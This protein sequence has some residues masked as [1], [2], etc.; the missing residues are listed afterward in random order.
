MHC[1]NCSIFFS[2]FLHSSFL[3]PANK[4][5]LLEWKVRNDLTMYAS[6]ASPSLNLSEITHYHSSRDLSWDKLFQKANRFEDDGHTSKLVRAIAHGEK[7][8][9]NFEGKEG[10]VIKGDMWRT[11]GNMVIDSVEAG[12]PTWV[13]SC[14]FEQAW[15]SVPERETSRL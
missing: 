8:C 3:S 9:A 6:R 14:G 10:F 12:G 13:R 15:E 7:A 2:A 4:V 11:L 1:V 5:R